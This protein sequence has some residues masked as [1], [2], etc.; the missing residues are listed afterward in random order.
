MV[1]SVF[2]VFVGS[3]YVF[4]GEISTRIL[5]YLK[6]L[7]I[8]IFIIKILEVGFGARSCCTRASQVALVVKNWPANAGDVRDVCSISGLGRS[9]GGGH[10]NPFQ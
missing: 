6:N 7:V 2:H 8:F 10:G 4:L 3:L 5:D 1:L 9:P